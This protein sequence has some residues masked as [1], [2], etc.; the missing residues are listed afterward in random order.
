M[1]QI[2][3]LNTK[4]KILLIELCLEWWRKLLSRTWCRASESSPHTPGI[5]S[6]LPVWKHY[7]NVWRH[8]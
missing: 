4:H 1:L 6:F 8:M 3:E 5:G 7:D 2:K